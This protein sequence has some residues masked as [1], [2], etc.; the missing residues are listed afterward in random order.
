M[1]FENHP[2]PSQ[3]KT[4]IMLM[5]LLLSCFITKNLSANK[6]TPRLGI[7]WCHPP[8]KTLSCA[9]PRGGSHHSCPKKRPGGGWQVCYVS[10][11]PTKKKE[12]K[13]LSPSHYTGWL[14]NSKPQITLTYSIQTY[15]VFIPICGLLQQCR[16]NGSQG[17]NTARLTNAKKRLEM[18]S[19]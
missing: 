9:R 15:A 16:P 14:W 11:H 1:V 6:K 4:F 13:T 12:K 7:K 19:N 8:A 10:Y 2:P 5:L 18:E 17:C 3:V